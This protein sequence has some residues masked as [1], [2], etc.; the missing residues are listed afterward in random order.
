MFFFFATKINGT[1]FFFEFSL[2]CVCSIWFSVHWRWPVT[3]HRQYVYFI[4]ICCFVFGHLLHPCSFLLFLFTAPSSL[5]FPL[6]AM[7]SFEWPQI[8]TSIA[9][10]SASQSAFFKFIKFF[11]Y[12][13][14]TRSFV[15]TAGRLLN[16]FGAATNSCSSLI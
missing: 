15:R 16:I 14:Y 5:S 2:V 9:S 13:R 6:S 3:G 7:R 11:F 10:H 1:I 8:V 4:F 12:S